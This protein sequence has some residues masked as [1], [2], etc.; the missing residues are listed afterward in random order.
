MFSHDHR[1]RAKDLLRL[2]TPDSIATAIFTAA[3]VAKGYE[4]PAGTAQEL[5]R[6]MM[7]ELRQMGMTPAPAPAPPGCLGAFAIG[8]M[9]VA[10]VMEAGQDKSVCLDQLRAEARTQMAP[11]GIL[12]DFTASL[13]VDGIVR[14]S[15]QDE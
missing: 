9:V 14:V 5:Q 8:G 7:E 6:R 13:V 12:I 11:L 15:L 1:D 3:L 10:H 2:A 4:R